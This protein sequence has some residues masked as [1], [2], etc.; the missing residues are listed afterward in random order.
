LEHDNVEVFAIAK[1]FEAVIMDRFQDKLGDK[2][3]EDGQ[4]Y[5]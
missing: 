5:H 4:G 2:I 3:E 1:L